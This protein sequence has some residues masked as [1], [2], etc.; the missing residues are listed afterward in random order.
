MTGNLA[1]WVLVDGRGLAD[2]KQYVVGGSYNS[3][4]QE[5]RNDSFQIRDARIQHK[6]VGFRAALRWEVLREQ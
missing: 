5:C 3:T 1:E 4:A 6:D 2:N